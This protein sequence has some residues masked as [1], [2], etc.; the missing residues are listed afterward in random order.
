M[1][2]CYEVLILIFLII[3]IKTS[4]STPLKD[5]TVY[6]IDQDI[7]GTTEYKTKTVSFSASDSIY[8][9]KYDFASKVPSS[10]TTAFKIDI[11]PYSHVLNNYKVLCTNVPSSASDADLIAQLEQVKADESKSSCIHIYQYYG[12][13]DSLMKLDTAK[14]KIGIAVNIPGNL[15]TE[16]TINLRITEKILGT[17][18]QKPDF[19]ESHSIIP[20]SVKIEDFRAIP[21]SKILFLFIN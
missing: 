10:L 6:E 3:N 13:H 15:A 1:K 16:V 18:E 2:K 21:K 11:T 5:G 14:T 20:I 4:D 12:Y 17:S 8:Y 19:D 7:E 9:L